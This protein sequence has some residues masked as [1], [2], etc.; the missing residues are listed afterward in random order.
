MW[1]FDTDKPKRKQPAGKE[2]DTTKKLLG[3]KCCLC[4]KTEKTVGILEKA[5]VKAHSNGGTQ[6]VPMCKICHYKYDHNQLTPTQKKKLGI[7]DSDL[8]RLA[9]KTKP[10]PKAK[11]PFEW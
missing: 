8:K 5:H 1:D 11:G 7:S 6:C 2:W 10:K 4:G 9:P 3:G